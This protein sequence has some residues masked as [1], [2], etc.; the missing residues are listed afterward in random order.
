MTFLRKSGA[1]DSGRAHDP[2]RPAPDRAL[3]E[4]DE[5][6]ASLDDWL[7]AERCRRSRRPTRAG[8]PR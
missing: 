2:T 8:Q 7:D 6:R 4:L 3:M 5:F 1:Q